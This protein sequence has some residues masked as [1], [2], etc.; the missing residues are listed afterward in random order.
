MIGKQGFYRVAWNFDWYV[1]LIAVS[2]PAAIGD[3]EAEP[4]NLRIRGEIPL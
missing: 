1:Y 3:M 2:S 4:P